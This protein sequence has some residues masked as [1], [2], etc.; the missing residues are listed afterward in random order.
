MNLKVTLTISLKDSTFKFVVAIFKY[1]FIFTVEPYHFIVQHCTVYVLGVIGIKEI[2][3]SQ[4]T[5]LGPTYFKGPF[6]IRKCSLTKSLN[7]NIS[8][9]HYN[10]YN[11]RSELV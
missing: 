2:I 7:P 8:S 4:K 1:V 5:R 11:F 10:V 9:I 6:R 3:Y